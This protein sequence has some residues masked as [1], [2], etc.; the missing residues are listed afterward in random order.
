ME[1]SPTQE[2]IVQLK[3][4][5]EKKNLSIPDIVKLVA[6]TGEP[7]SESAIRRVFK[8]D[9][10]KTEN[11]NYD[12]TLRPIAQALLVVENPEDTDVKAFLAIND[13]KDAQIEELKRQKE[14]MR[15]QFEKRC[16]EYETRMAF[17]RDQ[18]EKKDDRMDRK[19]AMIEK[20]LDQVLVCGKCV[21]RDKQP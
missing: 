1:L 5:Q 6:S 18:I 8:K 17:L 20:L 15:E 9:S 13:Y 12:H 16:H 11:F 14:N 10:E 7:V 3:A 21:M 19:D 4:V 2:I